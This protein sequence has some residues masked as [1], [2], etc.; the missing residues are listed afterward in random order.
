M[1]PNQKLPSRQLWSFACASIQ[2]A[3]EGQGTGVHPSN[4]HLT[5]HYLY[6]RI[7][8]YSFKEHSSHKVERPT[9]LPLVTYICLIS[10]ANNINLYIFKSSKQFY[11]KWSLT[12]KRD[13]PSNIFQKN[14][15]KA[16]NQYHFIQNMLKLCYVVMELHECLSKNSQ[17]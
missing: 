7:F 12:L 2:E 17:C 4:A 5:C 6:W 11:I 8:I 9:H 14:F 3:H 13:L 1:I 10:L 15:Y 16:L